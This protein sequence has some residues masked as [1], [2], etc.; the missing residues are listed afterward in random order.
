MKKKI[1]S[2]II[3]ALLVSV[4]LFNLIACRGE[5]ADV[6]YDKTVRLTVEEEP[7]N[8]TEEV[9]NGLAS[10]Y[11]ELAASLIEITQEI[12]IEE[13]KDSISKHFKSNIMP[14][15]HRLKIYPQEAD[16]ILTSAEKIINS[17][18][19]YTLSSL[20]S[21]YSEALR[22]LGS[23]RSG[24]LMYELALITVAE[25][26]DNAKKGYEEATISA[27]KKSYY[28]NYIRC[29]G[30]LTDLRALGKEKFISALTISSLIFSTAASVGQTVKENAFSVSDAELLFI[31]DRQGEILSERCPT[32]DEWQTF[33]GLLSDLILK[34][35]DNLISSVFYAIKNYSHPVDSSEEIEEDPQLYPLLYKSTYL[36]TAL[37][38]MPKLFSLY[39][40]LAK[41]LK[42]QA[43]FSL[44][45]TDKEKKAAIIC[46]LSQCEEE[47]RELD[48]AISAYIP[49]DFDA[50]KN[51][52]SRYSDKEKLDA[53][54]NDGKPISIDNLISEIKSAADG[55]GADAE[56][57]EQIIKSYLF[58][59]SPYISFLIFG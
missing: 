31:L 47:L 26:R 36:A 48:R 8:Y 34:P 49:E 44:E 37:R 3:C 23:Q 28:K 50:L 21:I 43:K 51:N 42:I 16:A 9:T 13:Q 29:I 25:K 55:S 24:E 45:S 6:F 46:A 52:V 40:S 30:L 58:G 7:L 27:L 4:F 10:R 35:G 15:L 1:L 59:I 22:I 20:Y 12:K 33:G 57:S 5:E 56:R 2:K 54:L 14:V 41:N 19:E 11:T 32:E 38:A 53:F 18:K 17:N 39:R